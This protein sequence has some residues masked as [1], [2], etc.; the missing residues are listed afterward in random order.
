MKK[1]AD[2]QRNVDNHLP[3][4]RRVSNTQNNYRHEDKKCFGTL[5]SVPK[6]QELL[7]FAG[8]FAYVTLSAVSFQVKPFILS[9]LQTESG[10][11]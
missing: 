6:S 10:R 11:Y 8:A 7:P 5:Y 1:E 3:D 9:R 2:F 4:D